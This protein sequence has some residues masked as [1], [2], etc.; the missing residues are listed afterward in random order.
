[1]ERDSKIKV[2]NQ[3]P[4]FSEWSENSVL[5]IACIVAV[6]SM[7][8]HLR[9]LGCNFVHFDDLDYVVNNEVIRHLDAKLIISSFTTPH[10]IYVILIPITEIS[11]ALDYYV[12]GLNPQGYHLTNI[13][14]HAINSGLVVVLANRLCCT[15]F[16]GPQNIL[17]SKLAFPGMLL[18]AGLIFG[19]HPLRVE[20]VTWVSGRKDV[21]YVLFVLGAMI[22]YLRYAEQKVLQKNNPNSY[23][24]YLLSLLLF[25]LSLLAKPIGI[26][27]PL[28]LL[29]ADWYPLSRIKRGQILSV[30]IEKIPFFIVAAVITA[31]TI[32]CA[33]N[34]NLLYSTGSIPLVIRVVISGNALFEYLRLFLYPIGIIPFFALPKEIP[35]AY[36]VKSL[37]L[38]VFAC[39]CLWQYRRNKWITAAFFG[40]LIPF[41]PVLA[42]IQ[43]G[44]DAAF[45]ARYTYLP[46]VALSIAAAVLLVSMQEKISLKH[47]GFRFI[48][49]VATLILLL[50][51]SGMT[52]KLISGW[53][54]TESFWS[55]IIDVDPIGRAYQERGI[56]R[57]A[58]GKYIA[59]N[60]DF[61]AAIGIT[62]SLAML[63]N[64]NLFAH[65]AEALR[66]A[67]RY[68]EALLD[69]NRAVSI[70]PHKSYYHLRGLTFKS[71]GRQKEAALDFE[72][73]GPDP[74]QLNW[75]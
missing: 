26:I 44:P 20:S 65:R 47:N 58:T 45:A 14:L 69:F 50:F 3:K 74:P 35:Y 43:Q 41:L 66:K 51:Y 63:P 36:V 24:D 67:G 7:L 12:W 31:V 73:A 9:A 30:L 54:D 75:F 61:S 70:F 6:I 49:P 38:L 19:L 60:D 68:E 4:F 37:I 16:S 46:S 39:Y 52:I 72:R 5:C 56:Y 21:L 2:N 11:Y 13:L 48:I 8:I 17:R 28:M 18:L 25:T 64:Y 27:L 62:E 53:K 29:I 23:Q 55:R 10:L 71:L 15:N 57:L 59:A 40:Y 42:L 22:F 33:I 34:A 32:F 1:M